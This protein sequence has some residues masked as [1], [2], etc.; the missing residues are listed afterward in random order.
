MRT[1]I[2]T[3]RNFAGM[4]VKRSTLL[5]EDFRLRRTISVGEKSAFKKFTWG[6]N[7][8]LNVAVV[9]DERGY[10]LSQNDDAVEQPS[11]AKSARE[12]FE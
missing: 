6:E 5:D 7:S 9:D 2:R 12:A 4:R 3:E 10:P 1:H 11:A 8:S